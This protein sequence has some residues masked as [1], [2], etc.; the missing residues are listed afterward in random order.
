MCYLLSF[1]YFKKIIILHQNFVTTKW[2]LHPQAKNKKVKEEFATELRK[3]MI[4]QKEASS[5]SESQKP[6]STGRMLQEHFGILQNILNKNSNRLRNQ[7]LFLVNLDIDK[8]T[9]WTNFGEQNYEIF[10]Y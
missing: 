2:N 1:F 5:S 9:F 4:Q 10:F 6:G 8:T 7:K 3:V